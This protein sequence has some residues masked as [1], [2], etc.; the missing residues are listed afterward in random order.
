MYSID[1]AEGTKEKE[2][3]E[4]LLLST[5][6]FSPSLLPSFALLLGFPEQSL[7]G[8]DTGDASFLSTCIWNYGEADMYRVTHQIVPKLSI[9]GQR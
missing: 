1:T 5:P 7:I 8:N 4:L 3:V 2:R 9:Q 6:P